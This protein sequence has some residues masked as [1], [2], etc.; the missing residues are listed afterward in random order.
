[1][2]KPNPRCPVLGC[3]TDKPHDTDPLV[4]GM[5]AEFGSPE[6]LTLWT[7]IAMAEISQSICRDLQEK[8]IFAWLS[9][10]RQPEEIYVRTLYTLFIA[11]KE[12]LPH[13][14]SGDTPNGMMG[15][16][17]PVNK[18]VF[19]DR[20]LLDATQPGLTVGSFKA[21]DALHAGAH[22]SFSAIMTCIGLAHHPE[23]L[24][25][26]DKYIEHVGKYCTYLN[27]M[28]EMF[29]GGKSKQDVLA[30]VISLHNPASYWAEQQAKIK[31]ATASPPD[32]PKP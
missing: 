26:P 32:P 7:R 17:K 19:E 28:H 10:L 9:R 29:K 4:Q 11:T 3:R 12:E 2:K 21:V 1:M 30:G 5:L 6:K 15:Y 20:G 13:I 25:S 23:A 14:V 22:G 31:A 27:Y 18:L 24:P 8:K 16:Y